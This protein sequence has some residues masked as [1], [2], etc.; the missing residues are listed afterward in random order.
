MNYYHGGPPNL[1]VFGRILP[2]SKTSAASTA[3]Y[4]AEGICKRSKVYVVTDP[5][6]A[7]IFASMHPSGKGRIYKVKPIGELSPDPDCSEPGLSWECDEAKIVGIVG[8][9]DGRRSAIRTALLSL[10]AR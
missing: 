2:S 7:A 9:S 4:G 5:E 6:A 8:L 3:D 1:G 10:E